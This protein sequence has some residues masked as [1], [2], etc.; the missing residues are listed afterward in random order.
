M[1]NSNFSKAKVLTLIPIIVLAVTVIC[2]VLA[3]ILEVPTNRGVFYTIFA[4]A[5]L[6]SLFLAPLPCLVISV[7]GTMLAA[8]A[9]KEGTAEARIFLILGIIEIIVYVVGAILAVI[10]FMVGQ[11][12]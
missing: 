1:K 9:T 4:L 10:M 11:G 8:K 5:G 7:I 6:I 12:V 3:T 2:T